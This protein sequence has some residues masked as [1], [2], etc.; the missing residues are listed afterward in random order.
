MRQ[1]FGTKR[2]EVTSEWRRLHNEELH[3]LQSSPNIVWL[4]KS[5]KALGGTCSMHGEEERCVQGFEGGNMRE[6]DHSKDLVVDGRIILKLIFK[7]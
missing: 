2:V 4:I 3:D 5:N 7:K 1:V 6:R